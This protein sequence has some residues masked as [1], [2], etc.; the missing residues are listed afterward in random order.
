MCFKGYLMNQDYNASPF[1]SMPPF[2]VAMALLIAGIELVL[3][4]ADAGIIGGA[5]GVGWRLQ[6]L[7]SYAFS[8][9]AFEW[10]RSSGQ[11]PVEHM[12][13]FL[14]Y[15]FVHVSL[16]SAAFSI[17]F[18]LALG[19]MVGEA[20][21]TFAVVVIWVASSVVGALAYG[22][23]LDTDFPL[24]GGMTPAYGLIGAYSFMLWVGLSVS[25]SNPMM[26]FRLIAMLMGLQLFF[27]L[28]FGG[29]KDWVADLA[30]FATGFA[31]SFVLVP[32]GAQRLL[33]KMRRR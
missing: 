5:Q 18:L 23:V 4:A 12:L 1:N 7:Q 28:V 11:Y 17:V 19:K 26:A 9:R 8:D 16:M 21:G 32:G 6:A 20:F 3:Q 10:M 14:S 29:S 15:A 24:F 31:L 27:G 25:G 2:V 22:L 33:Q 30:G 13:R